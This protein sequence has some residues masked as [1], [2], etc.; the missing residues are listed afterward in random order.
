MA[1]WV[2]GG[3]VAGLPV[4]CVVSPFCL[5]GGPVEWREWCVV[6]CPRV[7]IGSSPSH[8]SRPSCVASPLLS[9]SPPSHC[10]VRSHSIVGLVLCLCGRVV[11]L[12]NS[13]DGLCWVEGRVVF[14]VY[15]LLSTLMCC[16]VCFSVVCVLWNSGARVCG[17]V[18]CL[19]LPFFPSSSISLV[20]GVRGSAR[21]ALRA[22]TLSPNTIA[23]PLLFRLLLSSV[24][25]H[26]PPFLLLE[27]RCVIHHVSVCCV[28]MTAMGSLSRSS[29]F[30]W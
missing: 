8:C 14:T 20:G 7:R 4:L 15:C 17:L 9:S 6:C 30:F 13:G 27:W 28:G 5:C 22:R 26:A 12:W 10:C 2:K 23:S 21:A 1:W 24:F 16:G 25:L 18:V 11:S 3:C 19:P 29:S